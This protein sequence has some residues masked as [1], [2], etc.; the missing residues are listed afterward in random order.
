MEK[1]ANP[2]TIMDKTIINPQR[3]IDPQREKLKSHIAWG[4]AIFFACIWVMVTLGPFVFMVVN[5]FRDKK[6]MAARACSISRI[7]GTSGI[8]RT[9]FRTD[10]S[11]SSSGA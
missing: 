10:F 2:Q 7:R 1:T 4:I 6:M 8:T 11:D 5:S 9:W 3:V